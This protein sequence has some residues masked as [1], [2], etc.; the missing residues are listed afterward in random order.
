[1]PIDGPRDLGLPWTKVQSSQRAKAYV[2]ALRTR[3]LS[4]PSARTTFSR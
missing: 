4:L 3:L 1:M 2:F